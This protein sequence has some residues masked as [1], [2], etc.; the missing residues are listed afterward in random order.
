LYITYPKPVQEL[1]MI[2]VVG[3][4]KGGSG[5][6]TIATNLAVLRAHS[7]KKLLLVDAD[8]QRSSSIFANQRDV[9]DISPKWSTVQLA[10]QSLHSQVNR[11]KSDY[12]DI[13]IDVGGR[14]TTSQR[15]ALVVADIFL[16]PFKPRSYD[17]WTLADVKT[18]IREMKLVNPKLKAYAFINQADPK[19]TDNED[20]FNILKECEELQCIN[21][22]IGNRKTFGNSS[23]DGLGVIE[24]KSPD[25]KAVNEIQE[26]Y[27]YVYNIGT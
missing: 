17:V 20:A 25:K 6:T 12:D 4:I 26:L 16:V 18:T 21:L 5:K 9:Q 19:G 2:V 13:I 7:G 1:Y 24:V 14:D 27:K 11:L 3:G 15:S 10:G 8:E 23:S 22:T